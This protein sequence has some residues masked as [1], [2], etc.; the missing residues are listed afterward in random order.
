MSFD[1]L[2]K[3]KQLQPHAPDAEEISRLLQAAEQSL[4]DASV[5]AI[6]PEHRFDAGYKAIMQTAR[7]LLLSH[8]YRPATSSPGQ[9]Q[10]VIQLLP[11]TLGITSERLT[12]LDALRKQRHL[13]DYTGQ[14]V[15]EESLRTCIDEAIKLRSE[16]VAW[17][18]ANKPSLI[19]R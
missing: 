12:I 17:L 15:T 6:S 19:K 8:G 2:L 18:K 7:A 3:T 1:N 11:T 5:K 10:L 4:R 14:G 13:V 16:A 9:H